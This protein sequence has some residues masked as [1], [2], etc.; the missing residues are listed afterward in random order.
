MGVDHLMKRPAE[1]LSGERPSPIQA[2]YH[3]V[4]RTLWVMQGGGGVCGDEADRVDHLMKRFCRVRMCSPGQTFCISMAR[5]VGV[6][7]DGAGV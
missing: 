2:S 1:S 3:P 5:W 6:V 4:C 7:R